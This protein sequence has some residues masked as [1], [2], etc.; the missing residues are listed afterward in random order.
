LLY[1]GERLRAAV[2]VGTLSGIGTE[3]KASGRAGERA[4]T[5]WTHWR[6][7]HAGVAVAAALFAGSCD[8]AGREGRQAALE[9]TGKEQAMSL[10]LTSPSFQ[11]TQ[12]IPLRF[13]CDGEDLSPELTWKG[14]PPK[15]ASFLLICD[16]PDAPAGDWVHWVLYD[17]PADSSGVPEGT[18]R[19]ERLP[20]GGVHGRNSWG[21][22]GWGG[23][24]PPSGTHRYFF[25]LYAVDGKL[26]LE[27]GATKAQVLKAA[28]GRVLAQAELMG[29]YKRK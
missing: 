5:P 2:T 14:T 3:H 21:K 19:S 12:M 6:T 16:D 8:G 15:T 11:H 9:K 20:S 26:E 18:P 22:L 29:R 17:L 13:T 7:R 1:D 27:P 10:T 24:C 28:E 25:R 4:S 23:P